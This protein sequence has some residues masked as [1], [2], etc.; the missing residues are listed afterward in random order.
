MNN[1][2]NEL[3]PPIPGQN[4]L[5]FGAL[6]GGSSRTVQVPLSNPSKKR[7]LWQADT[8]AKS[9][10]TVD[11]SAGSL[12]PGEKKPVN[13]TA[14]S[15]TLAI[16][17]YTATLT[18]TSEGDD[19]SAPVHVPVTLDIPPVLPP[20]V[21]L[22]FA[23]FFFSSKTIPLAIINQDSQIVN[24][25][26]TADTGGKNWLTLDRYSGT[27]NPHEVQTLY[28]TARSG[29][30]SEVYAATLTFTSEA[31]GIKSAEVQLPVE[32]QVSPDN[33]GDNGPHIVV[34]G[35]NWLD[36]GIQKQGMQPMG[37][38]NILSVEAINPEVNGQIVW[39]I[40][41][42]GVSWLKLVKDNGAFQST[43]PGPLP[44][45][46]KLK[47]FVTTDIRGLPAGNYRTDL[48]LTFA[49]DPTYDPTKAG[50]E[51][52]SALIPVTMIIP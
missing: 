21:G 10:L 27:I 5:N 28:V 26:A 48:I 34:L 8:D 7:M 16:G 29:V 32:L 24:W 33:E 44:P 38:S 51:P 11:P 4:P 37:E 43:L 6:A 46:G 42:G 17:R 52:A 15:S 31:G 47:V 30:V 49:F 45:N 19:L 13:V 9:W 36:L 12:E 25:T 41:T 1:D 23:L 50:R 35:Q 2:D 39:A 14:D 18:F 40:D 20:A 22:S 3:Q